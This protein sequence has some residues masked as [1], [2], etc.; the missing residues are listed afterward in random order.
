MSTDTSA[1]ADLDSLLDGTLDDL[2]DLPTFNPYPAGAHRAFVYFEE[3]VINKKPAVE[4]KLVGIATE[5]LADATEDKPIEPKQETQVLYI[6][7]KDDGTVNEVSQGKLKEV[8]A[9]L[10]AATGETGL[11]KIMLA[12]SGMEVLAITKK[13]LNKQSDTYNTDIVKLE[14]V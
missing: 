2:A 13:R 6:L 14:V 12:A 3:K 11:R 1:K 4:L 10:G 8:L 5:E 7:K 9:P